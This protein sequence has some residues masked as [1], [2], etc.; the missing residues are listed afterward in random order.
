MHLIDFNYGDYFCMAY[1]TFQK[2]IAFSIG[3]IG[4]VT[5]NKK[6]KDFL[7]NIKTEIENIQ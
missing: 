3:F 4:G 7:N 2:E 6:V 1:S 5:Q